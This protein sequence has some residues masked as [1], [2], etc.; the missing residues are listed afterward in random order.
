[1]VR[2][3]PVFT[4]T[5]IGQ[6]WDILGDLRL[7][8]GAVCKCTLFIYTWH[9]WQLLCERIDLNKGKLSHSFHNIMLLLLIFFVFFLV[10]G[11]DKGKTPLPWWLKNYTQVTEICLAVHPTLAGHHQ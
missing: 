4:L 2:T 5:R 9:G 6:G 10:G 8:F 1:M 3:D 11:F 7:F